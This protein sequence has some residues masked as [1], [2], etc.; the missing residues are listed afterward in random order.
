MPGLDDGAGPGASLTAIMAMP[1]MPRM[2]AG[3]I[4]PVIRTSPPPPHIEGP[5]AAPAP[6]LSGSLSIRSA[7][8][9]P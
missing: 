4:A 3:E 6:Q 2:V 9:A 8:S 1:I 7:R 5:P